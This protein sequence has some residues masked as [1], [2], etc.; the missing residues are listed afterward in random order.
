MLYEVITPKGRGVIRAEVVG[1]RGETVQL[2]AFDETAGIEVGSR[3]VAS[4]DLLSVAVSPKLLGRTLD[5]LGLPTD[6]KGDIES[7]L[8][9]PAVADAPDPLKRRRI[10][11]RVATGV[12]AL[13]GLLPV[14][15]GVITS[16]SIH[17][18][19]LY[20]TDELA[21]LMQRAMVAAELAGMADRNNF[22]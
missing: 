13:D 5:A 15:K 9:Y 2:M 22:V 4:G 19:K 16:Y 10:T 21:T 6:G 7:S 18:T 8:R 20:D 1:L 3:V 17:Y 14:G 11:R 12:R